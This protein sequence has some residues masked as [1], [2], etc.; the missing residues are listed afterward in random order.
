MRAIAR[1]GPQEMALEQVP[2]PVAEPG[3]VIVHPEAVGSLH[4][5]PP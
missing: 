3:T 5:S 4:A 2:E 1:N